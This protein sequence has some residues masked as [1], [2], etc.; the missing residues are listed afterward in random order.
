MSLA[1]TR[2]VFAEGWQPRFAE[3][4]LRGFEDFFDYDGGLQVNRNDKRN[5]VE[6]RF[7]GGDKPEIFYRKRFFSPYW[8]DIFFTLRNFGTICSQAACEWKNAH[9][10]LD[11]GVETYRP[12]CYG[13]ETIFGIERRSFFVTARLAGP[14]LADWLKQRGPDPR[15]KDL[16]PMV[17]ELGRLFRRVHDA[18]IR[19]PD[20]YV[21]HVFLTGR[22]P[23]SPE[24][25]ALIDLHRMMVR[26]KDIAQ[27]VRDLG[28]FLYSMAEPF[29]HE[30]HRKLLLDSYLEEGIA[31]SRVQ[32]FAAIEQRKQLLTRRRHVPEY[33]QQE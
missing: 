13:E 18:G 14:C 5:V 16:E 10:L 28:A 12:V 20:L 31:G 15:S 9:A 7:G 24:S 19:M 33:A 2:L 3:W 17:K 8:K 4:G 1:R 11:I 25:F 29:F 27:R 23:W 32:F 22:Q 21:W 30:R 26:R 6:M